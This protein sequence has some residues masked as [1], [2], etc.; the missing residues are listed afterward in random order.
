[1]DETRRWF[2][3]TTA[4]ALAALPLVAACVPA[5]PRAVPFTQDTLPT[6]DSQP[7][8]DKEWQALTQ[9]GVIDR[10]EIDYLNSI[11]NDPK[12]TPTA[13]SM[14]YGYVAT[15]GASGFIRASI[16]K[17]KTPDFLKQQ[18]I[19][20]Q[21]DLAMSFR[22]RTVNGGVAIYDQRSR[23]HI[24]MIPSGSIQAKYLAE[25][26]PSWIKAWT[27]AGVPEEYIRS[28]KLVSNVTYE[29]NSYVALV[30]PHMG[31][32]LEGF[33]RKHPDQ[34]E[35]VAKLLG[36]Y[37]INVLAP[38]NRV[39]VVQKDLNF[40][41]IVMFDKNPDIF[42]PIDLDGGT[43]IYDR[44]I[45]AQW[46]YEEMADRAMRRGVKLPSFNDFVSQNQ[47]RLPDLLPFAQ[48]M[49]QIDIRID[50]ARVKV[51]VPQR[52]VDGLKGD[53][54]T[55]AVQAIRQQVI[56][57]YRNAR[58]GDFIPVTIVGKDGQSASLNIVKTSSFGEQALFEG[59]RAGK[60]LELLK[61][62]MKVGEKAL[63][64]LWVLDTFAE[65]IADPFEAQL[66]SNVAFPVEIANTGRA[67]ISAEMDTMYANL[68]RKKMS[69][70]DEVDNAFSRRFNEGVVQYYLGISGQD[71]RTLLTSYGLS[72][73]D[74]KDMCINKMAAS[75]APLAQIKVVFAD[76][77]PG[78]IGSANPETN[79]YLSV[80]KEGTTEVVFMWVKTDDGV[81]LVATAKKDKGKQW[82]LQNMTESKWTI[83]FDAIGTG[84]VILGCSLNTNA[85]TQDSKFTFNC[86]REK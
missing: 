60:A 75:L 39:G 79:G 19:G 48:E 49:K 77:F 53:E 54:M 73:R 86:S 31:N 11:G 40:R 84:K 69:A 26:A 65:V 71:L 61:D 63:F 80:V 74:V 68:M 10:F 14:L 22:V 13:Q 17:I 38:A 52:Y 62:T 9:E 67:D 45:V 37:Y 83:T 51:I 4:A 27:E 23:M 25:S 76:P 55:A 56:D 50:G 35:R 21:D 78:L 43:S 8:S 15:R 5:A 47:S 85:L 59:G 18:G 70:L 24:K 64:A 34:A 36:E 33:I 57:Q 2:L 6:H 42:L 29:G 82:E 28:I 30:T 44:S 20:I 16:D 41:N 32:T 81:Q 46:Q 1:M 3:R 72:P 58:Q 7:V 66:Q 12:L